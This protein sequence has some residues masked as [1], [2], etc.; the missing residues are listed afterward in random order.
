MHRS[1]TFGRHLADLVR[2]EM[3]STSAQLGVLGPVAIRTAGGVQHQV[4]GSKLRVLL[5]LLVL[6]RNRAVSAPR[7]VHGLWGDVPPTGADVTLR[8]HVSH[9][10][11]RLADIAPEITL[12]TG[13]AGYVLVLEP[14]QVDVERFE[15]LVGLAQEAL[16]L[17]RP[18]RAA[19]HVREALGLWRGGPYPELEEVDDAAVEAARLEEVRLGALEVLAAA[20]LAAGQSSRPPGTSGPRDTSSDRSTAAVTPCW[21]GSVSTAPPW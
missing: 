9:L 10:R 11:R 15:Q 6:H 14:G 13:P 12:S 20:E 16:G 18:Q 7:L 17:D 3:T 1:A 2:T 21:A 19:S 5:S 4:G 8:S